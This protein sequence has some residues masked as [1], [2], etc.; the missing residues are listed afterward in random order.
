MLPFYYVAADWWR[1]TRVLCRSLQDDDGNIEGDEGYYMSESRKRMVLNIGSTRSKLVIDCVT[2]TMTGEY[3]CVA[4]VPTDRVA[5]ST[6]VNVG[7][8]M[9]TFYSFPNKFV[10]I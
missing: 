4:D 2:P 5:A 1:H 10:N 8:Y 3:S 7:T 6:Q 9:A